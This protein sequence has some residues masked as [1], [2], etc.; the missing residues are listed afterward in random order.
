[1]KKRIDVLIVT[2]LMVCCV[3]QTMAQNNVVKGRIIGWPMSGGILY[4]MGTGYERII[5]NHFSLQALVN[6]SGI[7]MSGYDGANEV[8]RSLI[9]EFRYFFK[10]KKQAVFSAFFLST[11]LEMQHRTITPGNER[12]PTNYL[13]I[14]KQKQISPG[15]LIGKNFRFS[16]K[17]HLESYIGSKYRIGSE[18]EEEVTNNSPNSSTI[19]YKKW[20]IRTGSNIAYRF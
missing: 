15:L 2:L 8:Y 7:N 14:N 4:S 13:I 17:W 6:Q 3:A 5:G 10:T 11:F 16:Q 12:D 1:M 18:T 19:K 9:P 20:G